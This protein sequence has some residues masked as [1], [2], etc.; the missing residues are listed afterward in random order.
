MF[1][2][3][4]EELVGAFIRAVSLNPSGLLDRLIHTLVLPVELL[5]GEVAL[6]FAIYL[7]LQSR[8]VLSTDSKETFNALLFKVDTSD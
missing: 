4:E 7:G 6:H 3:R 2:V 5:N 1:R 8:E